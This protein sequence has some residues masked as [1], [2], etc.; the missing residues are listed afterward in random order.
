MINVGFMPLY[1]NRGCLVLVT[2]PL[3]SIM[4]ENI[5]D[6]GAVFQKTFHAKTSKT[7]P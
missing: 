2:L 7:F 5:R 3:T 1:A 6:Y 4:D